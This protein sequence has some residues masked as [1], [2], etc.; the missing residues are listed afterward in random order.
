MKKCPTFLNSYQITDEIS[1]EIK[2][3]L[4]T[5]T[6]NF[7]IIVL[8]KWCNGSKLREAHGEA[9]R[10][11]NPMSRKKLLLFKNRIVDIFFL[12]LLAS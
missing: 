9:S 10:R 2:L 4:K 6:H 11:I 3:N 1:S 12:S 7:V 5:H 8:T